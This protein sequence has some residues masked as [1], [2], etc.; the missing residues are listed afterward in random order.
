M[1]EEDK[2]LQK[3]LDGIV[4]GEESDEEVK[5]SSVP[6][7]SPEKIAMGKLTND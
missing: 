1:S 2:R 4:D 3:N 5:E 7:K 6:K